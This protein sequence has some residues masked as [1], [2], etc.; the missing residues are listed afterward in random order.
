[1][2]IIISSAYSLDSQKGNSITAQR[3]AKLLELAGHNTEAVCS[4]TLPVSDVLIAL[5]ATKTLHHSRSFKRQN[6]RGNL[7]IYLT[8]TDLYRELPAGNPEFFEALEIADSLVVSQPTSLHSIPAA[9][10]HKSHVVTASVDLPE[11]TPVTSPE[12]PSL[13]LVG[14]LRSVKNPFLLTHALALLPDLAVQA[15]S[16]GESREEAM[17]ATA[18]KWEQR[19]PRYQW[20]GNLPHSTTL[21]W[22]QKVTATLNTSHL[23]GG[24][25]SVAESIVLGTPVLASR[26]EGNVGMLGDDYLGYFTPNSPTELAAL[27]QRTLT[28]SDFLNTL[29]EQTVKRQALFSTESEVQGWLA[30]L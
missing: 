17:S 30:L 20:L 28:D 12:Q 26:I 22:M 19:E 3:I 18:R 21:G 4:G 15:Y 9:Y 11:I 29:K 13:A 25:N 14:H 10:R 5:H 8:G 7:I 1:M 2:H 16:I 27:I 24:A 23:E 6:P